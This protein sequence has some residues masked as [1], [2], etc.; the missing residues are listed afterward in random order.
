MDYLG[1]IDFYYLWLWGVTIVV[2][3]LMIWFYRHL[4]LGYDLD[5]CQSIWYLEYV[6]WEIFL[7]HFGDVTSCV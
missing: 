6:W 1:Q 4:E 3:E 7:N 5:F 2:S